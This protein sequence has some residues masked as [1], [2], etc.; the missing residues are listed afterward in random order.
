MSV[1][2][3]L[4]LLAIVLVVPMLTSCAVGMGN[5]GPGADGMFRWRNAHTGWTPTE[6]G[7]D[8]RGRTW[9][10]WTPVFYPGESTKWRGALTGGL[11]YGSESASFTGM[12]DSSFS[13]VK[14]LHSDVVVNLP[15]G[16]MSLGARIGYMSTRF[17]GS[18]EQL[19]YH[20]YSAGPSVFMR[21]FPWAN[22]DASW[23]HLFGQ[24]EDIDGTYYT[25]HYNFIGPE[26]PMP[27]TRMQADVN[28][29]LIRSET[30]DVGVR[31][32]YQKTTA[33]PD[34]VFT[35]QRKFESKGFF[36]EMMLLKF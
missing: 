16:V 11:T 18:H 8:Y 33:G 7:T 1:A 12:R 13:A 25:P 17:P 36:G 14:R 19:E 10:K 32:G 6:S 24:V 20:G 22:I 2:A 26:V 15:G 30:A 28:I 35:K 29:F 27:G 23:E 21:L 4:R 5:Y 9:T 31:V 3:R 34:D